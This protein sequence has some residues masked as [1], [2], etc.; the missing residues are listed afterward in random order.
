MGN[1]QNLVNSARNFACGLYRQQPGA[2][3]PNVGEST[4]R[5]LWDQVCDY[6]G[7]PGLPPPPTSPF[8]GAQCAKGLYNIDIVYTYDGDTSPGEQPA[9]D[10][11]PAQAYGAIGG[12]RT[13]ALA[14]NPDGTSRIR[15]DLLCQGLAGEVPTDVQVWRTVVS[16]VTLY[17]S[18]RAVN[19]GRADGGLD[20]CGSLPPSY[21]SAPPPPPDGYTSPLT[22]IPL[23]DGSNISVNFN[24]SPPST[25]EIS[26]FIPPLIVN[27]VRPELKIPIAFNFN[28]D[29]NIGTPSPESLPPEVFI[30]LN[31]NKASIDSISNEFNDYR[32]DY[33]YYFSPPQLDNDPETIKEDEFVG[34][35]K[36]DDKSGIVGLRVELTRLPDKAQYGNPTVYFAGWMAFKREQGY[37]PREQVNFA[38]S[39]FLA[40]PGATGYTITFTNGAEGNIRIYSRE[41]LA[42]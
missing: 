25:P 40:P 30:S 7:S 39:F 2:L 6:P 1:F 32:K 38:D 37:L 3:I 42:Q 21:P 29:I 9:T 16:S 27:V 36:E 28:G 10:T 19:K 41:N 34:T 20:N 17:L 18:H 26:D 33:N 13:V 12:T 31:E 24:F 15:I 4:L 11:Q 23:A 8:T 22:P 5:F 35:G 14:P